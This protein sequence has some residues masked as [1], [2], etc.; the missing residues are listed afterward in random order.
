MKTRFLSTAC[1]C[2]LAVITTT[3]NAITILPLESRLGGL[4][5]YDP[6][7]DITWLANANANGLMTWSQANTWATGLTIDGISGW[8]LP[9]TD[10]S[11]GYSAS[12]FNEMGF[13]F[14]AELGGV[15]GSP[16]TTTHNSNYDL[17]QNLLPNLY[18]TGTEITLYPGT[19]WGFTFSTGNTGMY[20]EGGG[21][22][23]MAIHAGDVSAV[24]IPAAMWLFGSG[25]LGLIG[26]A[27][28]KAA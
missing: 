5:I 3:A 2:V 17:F 16:I 27:R 11:S 22:Y 12:Y 21:Q 14:F 15:A 18:W 13:L 1:A 4:A 28:R 6:N 25:L 19:A 10:G 23:A 24:P 9:T 26:M 8:R 7:K 20:G